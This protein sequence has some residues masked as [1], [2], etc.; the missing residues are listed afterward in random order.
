MSWKLQNLK[1]PK[2]ENPKKRLQNRKLSPITFWSFR[3]HGCENSKIKKG[4]ENRFYR[5]RPFWLQISYTKK[6][7]KNGQFA[8]ELDTCFLIWLSRLSS[9]LLN[10][11]RSRFSM[12]RIELYFFF[13][14]SPMTDILLMDAMVGIFWIEYLPSVSGWSCESRSPETSTSV[15]P[16]NLQWALPLFPG[17]INQ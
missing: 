12:S 9:W 11:S 14:V 8:H 15:P 16:P 2:H 7:E 6:I 13:M 17:Y 10:V 5:T 4:R 1:T 3:D